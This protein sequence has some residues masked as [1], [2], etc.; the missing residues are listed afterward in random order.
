MT[1][2]DL[3]E[4][5][6]KIYGL[7]DRRLY[8]LDDFF[9]Y[10]E[11]FLL[12]YLEAKKNSDQ[13][14][15]K[16]NLMIAFAWFFAVVNHF[17]INLSGILAKRYSYKCPFCLEIPCDCDENK[18]KKS[19]KTGRP[20]SRQ[21][22][23]ISEWQEII[24][25]VYPDLGGGS[26]VKLLAAKDRFHFTFRQFRRAS[27]VRKFTEVESQSADYFV[28]LLRVLNRF[29]IDLGDEFPNFFASGCFVCHKTPCQCFYSE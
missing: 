10:H 28:F 22:E 13:S 29:D 14:E 20:I 18:T 25:K 1:I 7:P 16:K 15:M 23:T 24:K 11:K 2:S 9:Y 3:L 4:I 8:D 26:G 5:T 12:R 21:P 17:E 27:G 19:Q 6:E